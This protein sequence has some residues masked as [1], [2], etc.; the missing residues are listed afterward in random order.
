M[1]RGGE[2]KG[3]GGVNTSNGLQ[4]RKQKSM[5]N[6]RLELEKWNKKDE[7]ATVRLFYLLKNLRC[8]NMKEGKGDH[9]GKS[10]YGRNGAGIVTEIF[11]KKVIFNDFSLKK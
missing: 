3:E 4:N 8:I 11:Q 5:S 10:G 7:V 1:C 6:V 2:G 9:V